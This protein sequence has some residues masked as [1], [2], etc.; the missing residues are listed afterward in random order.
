MPTSDAGT[1]QDQRLGTSDREISVATS[2]EQRALCA[3]MASQCRRSLEI[4]SR[5][6]DP[7]LYDTAEFAEALK[8]LA[9]RHRKARVRILVMDPEPIIRQGHRLLELAGRLSSFIE[10]RVPSPEHQNCNEAFMI[11]DGVGYIY[12]PLADRYD[13]KAN[14]HHPA[15]ARE[16]TQRFDEIWEIAQLDPNL[17]KMVL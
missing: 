15:A 2:L 11:A 16:L 8:Q 10:L 5:R 4:M 12:R 13:G 1:P 14:F 6:L 7:P 17:R 3:A 9:I